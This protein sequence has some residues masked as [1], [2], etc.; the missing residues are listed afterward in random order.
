MQSFIPPPPS[1][2][3]ATTATNTDTIIHDA[4]VVESNEEKQRTRELIREVTRAE[5][6]AH[7][8]I[9][10]DN[11]SKKSDSVEPLEEE[12]RILDPYE[13][14][15]QQLNEAKIQHQNIIEEDILAYTQS[16]MDIGDLHYKLG[17]MEDSQGIYMDA[18]QILIKNDT[19]KSD[20]DAD[21]VNAHHTD[22][23]AQLMIS[24]CMHSLG[25]IHARCQEYDDAFEWYQ[26]AL[27]KKQ[28]MLDNLYTIA[29]TTATAADDDATSSQLIYHYEIGKTYNGLAAL[30]VMKGG[31]VQWTKAM[32]L[33]QEAERNYLHG[34]EL[35]KEE[36][37]SSDNSL[38]KEGLA[39]MSPHHV[40]SLISVRGNMGEL[41]RQSGQNEQA[42]EKLRSAL[43]VA[44]KALEV[45]HDEVSAATHISTSSPIIDD[46]SPEEQMNKIVELQL[47]IADTLMAGNRFDEA[48]E[49]YEQA[50]N[51][52]KHFRKWSGKANMRQSTTNQ[53][54]A[55]PAT[56]GHATI[57][58]LDLTTA[59]TVEAAIRNNLAKALANIGQEKLSLEHYTVSLAIKR[60]FGGDLHMEVASTLMQ[61]GALNGGP[62]RDLT[63]A[64]NCFKEALYIYRTNLEEFTRGE[65][66]SASSSQVF[67]GE[68]YAN[69]ID[70]NIQNAQKNIKMIEAA[71]LKERDGVSK[72]ARRR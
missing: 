8:I 23:D 62:L 58:K 44:C 7:S 37:F 36:S 18:L 57:V 51:S 38:T 61:L 9:P 1:S 25:A 20:N 46:P 3:N 35:E 47:Q 4:E 66:P 64:L 69:E 11:S 13:K 42:V 71:L 15:M 21:I 28:K 65:T 72:K 30:E 33:F 53:Q 40:E 5:M 17:H 54:T 45:A 55:L 49:T 56:V 32:A 68:D 31:D 50:L 29:T 43:D 63:K 2:N 70:M 39:K 14:R 22:A 52:H 6:S 12:E 59:T 10:D 34:Y 16:C 26:E 19:E 60:H 67:F 24:Q 48:A 41:L 27:K